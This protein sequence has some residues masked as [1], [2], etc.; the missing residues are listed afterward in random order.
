MCLRRGRRP[1]FKEETLSYQHNTEWSGQGVTPTVIISFRAGDAEASAALIER[2]L[3]RRFGSEKIFR[4]DRSVLAGD[5]IETI[6]GVVRRSRALVAAIGQR[7]LTAT[8]GNGRRAIDSAQDWLRREIVEAHDHGVQVIPV[9]IGKI[10]RLTASDVPP[11]ME[12]LPDCKY[13]RLS[14]R[15]IDAGLARL[16]DELAGLVPGLDAGTRREPA[17]ATGSESQ[18]LTAGSGTAGSGTARS[19]PAGSG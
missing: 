11:A 12:W 13:L 3:S 8:D 7:W 2:E 5:D 10:P 16:A 9:L 6:M 17:P 18:S 19:G 15:D 14:Y 4:V 1:K